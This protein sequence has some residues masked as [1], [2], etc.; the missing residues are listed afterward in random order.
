MYKKKGY[1]L[2]LIQIL[3]RLVI[4]SEI[5]AVKLNKVTFPWI[6]VWNRYIIYNKQV[7][8]FNCSM[9]ELDIVKRFVLL[10]LI[11]PVFQLH[12]LSPPFDGLIISVL[13]MKQRFT[14]KG[15]IWI[16]FCLDFVFHLDEAFSF[17]HVLQ[18]L[19]VILSAIRILN[20]FL[21]YYHKLWV[22][23]FWSDFVQYI[24]IKY[25]SQKHTIKGF[26]RTRLSMLPQCAFVWILA[27]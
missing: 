25:L 17:Q 26:T 22:D 3:I 18:K 1:I 20:G 5:L 27:H 23:F 12:K 21:V 4:K 19:F 9:T 16:I 2:N 24:T 10:S 15:C 6:R 11:I 8:Q 7:I 14:Y 13:W